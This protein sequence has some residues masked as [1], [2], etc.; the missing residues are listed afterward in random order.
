MTAY[1]YTWDVSAGQWCFAGMVSVRDE[2]EAKAHGRRLW[3]TSAGVKIDL[4]K[5]IVEQKKR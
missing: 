4:I 5:T 3:G 1:L 2:E